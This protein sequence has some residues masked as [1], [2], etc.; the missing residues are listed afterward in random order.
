L[1]DTKPGTLVGTVNYMSPEQL[2]GEEIDGR[3]D[4][5]SLGVV[6]FEMLTGSRP[7]NGGSTSDVIAAVLER[8]PEPVLFPEPHLTSS[9]GMVIGKA[10][11]KD[12]A[13]RYPDAQSIVEDLRSIEIS[14]SGSSP[15]SLRSAIAGG[16]SS[17][18]EVNAP[19]SS[20]KSNRFATSILNRPMILAAVFLA[21]IGLGLIYF[22]MSARPDPITK[23]TRSKPFPVAGHVVN[24]VIS[25][26][27][28]FIAYVQDDAGRQSLRLRQVAENADSLVI[29]PATVHFAGI[30]F[31]PD[32][33]SIF[34]STFGGSPT[35]ELYRKAI[36]GGS[37]QKILDDIDSAVSFAPDGRSF[38]F[39]R[40]DA[41]GGRD[42]LMIADVDGG[43]LRVLSERRYPHRYLMNVREGV[44]WSRDGTTIASAAGTSDGSGERMTVVL[45]DVSSGEETPATGTSWYRVGRVLWAGDG[46]GLVITAAEFGTDLYQIWRVSPATGS[47]QKVT[48]E[49]NDYLNISQSADSKTLLALADDRTCNLFVAPGQNAE[50]ATQI[51]GGNLDG[52]GGLVWTPE[53]RLLYVSNRSGNRDIWLVD[54]DGGEPSQL[55]FDAAADDHPSISADGGRIA[56]ASSRAGVPHVWTMHRDGG[57]L[58]QLTRQGGEAFPQLSPDGRFVFY[59]ASPR[60]IWKIA[61]DGGEPLLATETPANW[62]AISPDG[63]KF[64]ALT[65]RPGVPMALTVFSVGTGHRETNYPLAGE[66][67]TPS[68]PPA[69]RWTPDGNAVAYVSTEDGVS[70]IV[71]QELNK[72]EPRRVTNF[73]ADRIFAFDWSGDGGRLAFARGT[74]RNKLLLFEDF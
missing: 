3:T 42:H 67:A 27:G 40:S 63:R 14:I 6:L 73:S 15:L 21:A 72:K 65:M 48:T 22:L 32:S 36:L 37:A 30:Q 1:L 5:W 49:L 29:S 64:A 50:R 47:N 31:S 4:L 9:V 26:N 34:Y 52:M 45:V 7:F 62:V 12:K 10:L 2:R 16:A 61:T 17:V 43:N 19:G 55:T 39:I 24:A 20:S 28:Q 57:D 66:V 41:H 58:R 33:N 11:A 74:A 56:F 54:P 25:P 13:A 51:A 68:F 71:I 69:I 8:A 46:E 60:R 44:A 59:S 23:L 53:G 18:G 70:N 38:A 35:G